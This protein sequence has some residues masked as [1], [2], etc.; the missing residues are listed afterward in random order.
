MHH[1]HLGTIL[2]CF[3]AG[4][5]MLLNA[6]NTDCADKA[7]T[8]SPLAGASIDKSAT[9]ETD[10]TGQTPG[11]SGQQSG[12]GSDPEFNFDYPAHLLQKLDITASDITE[13]RPD[14]AKNQVHTEWMQHVDSAL[15]EIDAEKRAAIKRIHTSLLFIKEM[16]D[17]SFYS[18]TIG[19]QEY[20]S[21][22][23]ELM[24]WFQEANRRVLSAREYNILFDVSTEE[25]S[26]APAGNAN[27][28]IQFPVRNPA[29]TDQMIHEALDDAT[30]NDLSRFYHVHSQELRDIRK[31][32]D[33]GDFNG[34][35]EQQVKND[36]KRIEKELADAFEKYCRDK[37]TDEE[38]KLLFNS[39]PPEP[40]PDAI[41]D[42]PVFKFSPVI[43]GT[44]VTHVFSI[45]NPG[46]A[47]LNI[48]GVYA[49]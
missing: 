18:S 41:I 44:E 8:A 31:I 1:K 4:L 46:G 35:D 10:A 33:S 34:A 47:D 48:P 32:Y 25:E 26:S 22:L 3:F 27:G 49:G 20:T 12:S 42:Q 17:K 6:A 38:F 39:P 40:G 11:I 15:P 23:S 7:V 16:L 30:I 36:I 37:L 21:R 43:A 24:Q 45:R 28:K 2:A 9:A 29:T 14:F 13:N 5:L 19:Q